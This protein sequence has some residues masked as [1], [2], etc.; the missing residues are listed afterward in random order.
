MYMNIFEINDSTCACWH[1]FSSNLHFILQ[2]STI[3]FRLLGL[4]LLLQGTGPDMFARL[5]AKRIDVEETGNIVYED[6]YMRLSSSRGNKG[7]NL[8]RIETPVPDVWYI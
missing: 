8:R 7:L 4:E 5:Q 2:V 3:V 6:F 1:N